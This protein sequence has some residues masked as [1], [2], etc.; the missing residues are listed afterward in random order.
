MKEDRFAYNEFWLNPQWHGTT[1]KYDILKWALFFL[2]I[3]YVSN[4]K[5]Q[6]NIPNKWNAMN[7]KLFNEKWLRNSVRKKNIP[8]WIGKKMNE[9][10]N[11]FLVGI[12][13]RFNAHTNTCK[14]LVQWR[15]VLKNVVL[16][17][18]VIQKCVDFGKNEQSREK[19]S[20]REPIQS[21]QYACI[22]EAE[23]NNTRKWGR[24]IAL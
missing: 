6:I 9:W 3:N 10:D 1:S 8:I 24:A 4:L 20:K 17:H 5:I 11:L 2:S 7:S 13:N 18:H 22:D 12:T 23:K 19:K 21:K 15:I 16:H 14:K